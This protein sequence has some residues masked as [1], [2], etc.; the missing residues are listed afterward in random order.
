[1]WI[2]VTCALHDLGAGDPGTY[3]LSRIEINKANV[4][5]AGGPVREQLGCVAGVCKSAFSNAAII[6]L[7]VIYA[8]MLAWQRE[9]THTP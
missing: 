4:S 5:G 9:H 1:M 7:L 6:G 2:C 3:P 8:E